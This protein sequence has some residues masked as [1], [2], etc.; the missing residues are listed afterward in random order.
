M[1]GKE[2]DMR[3]TFGTSETALRRLGKL[4]EIFNPSSREFVK[5]YLAHPV[6]AVIDLGCGPGFTTQMLSTAARSGAFY[7][8]DNSEEFLVSAREL[9][10]GGVFV[11]HDITKTPFPLAADAL[12]LRFVLSH[13]LYPVE[14]LNRWSREMR[15]DGIMLVEEVEAIETDSDVFKRYLSINNA[16]V[17]SQGA[18]LFIGKTLAHGTYDAQ[19]SLNECVSLPVSN[20]DAAAM[21]YPNTVSI[22]EKEAYVRDTVSAGERK[23][24]SSALRAVMQSGDKC[25]G[26]TWKM[27]RLVLENDSYRELFV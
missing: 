12:Y 24:I 6:N 23:D 27:R 14:L 5:K 11:N 21:F 13:L 17:A 20:S 4:A 7:G 26:I 8:F 10:S 3:Y 9:S 18:Q 1:P 25:C 16:L 19:V 22:W 15:H 2:I